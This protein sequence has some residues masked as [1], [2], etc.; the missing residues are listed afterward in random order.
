MR[1]CSV[2]SGT[3][4]MSSWFWPKPDW[5]LT[6]SRP[7]TWHESLPQPNARADR[8]LIAEQLLLDGVAEQAHRRAGAQLGLGEIAARRERPVAHFEELVAGA[9][10]LRRPVRVAVDRLRTACS[11]SARPRA[12]RRSRSRS[13]VTSSIV[14]GGDA[15]R[16]PPPPPKPWPRNTCSRFVPSFWMSACTCAV[17]PSPIVTIVI[18]A[19][20]PMTMPRIVSDERSTLR[21][22]S[23]SAS[24]MAFQNIRRA[25]HRRVR[26]VAF[27]AAVA[28]AHDAARP[29]G[30]VRLVR[31]HRR[32]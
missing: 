19:A 5:P 7:I 8:I 28:E 15:E 25:S 13:R 10:D 31:D 14:N 26:F 21:R 6:D 4:T 20:T 16:A 11:S 24:R 29:G 32:W 23:R 3:T 9:G 22:I 2:R 18:T 27:D 1:R 30:D 12:R 17:A